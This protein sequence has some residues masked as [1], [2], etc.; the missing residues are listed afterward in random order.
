MKRVKIVRCVV[1]GREF[2]STRHYAVCCSQE[3]RAENK[4][5]HDR[6]SQKRCSE[7]RKVVGYHAATKRVEALTLDSLASAKRKPASCSDARWRIELSR[8]RLA[9]AGLLDT[10]PDPDMLA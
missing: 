10:L 4:R 1:C 6:A 7:R 9:A 2:E 8:R 3:C 5:R